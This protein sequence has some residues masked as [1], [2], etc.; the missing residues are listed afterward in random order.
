MAIT[1]TIV[2]R[3]KF[4]VMTDPVTDHIMPPSAMP[5]NEKKRRD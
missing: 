4:G 3:I 5:K 2:R 1:W